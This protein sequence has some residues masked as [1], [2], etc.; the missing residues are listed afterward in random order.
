MHRPMIHDN[1][2]LFHIGD[3]WKKKI[4]NVHLY[5]LKIFKVV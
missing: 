3:G 5:E 2:S 1:V 4:T